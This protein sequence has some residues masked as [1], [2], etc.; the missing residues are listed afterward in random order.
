MARVEPAIVARTTG[1]ARRLRYHAG[2]RSSPPKEATSTRWSAS[3]IGTASI[4]E[5]SLPDL[6]PFVTSSTTGI[7]KALPKIRPFEALKTARW[8]AVIALYNA[9]LGSPRVGLL[10]TRGVE[11]LGALPWSS[12]LII[13][14]LRGGVRSRRRR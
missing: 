13:T 6:R 9:S 12:L 4:G 11:T 14:F 8:M 5:R 3:T 10:G 2:C 1:L 7:P